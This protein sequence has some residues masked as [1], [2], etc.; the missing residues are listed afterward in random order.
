VHGPDIPP[1]IGPTFQHVQQGATGERRNTESGLKIWAGS[2]GE[3]SIGRRG[4]G[5]VVLGIAQI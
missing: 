2:Q 4:V 3:E 1:A 5:N